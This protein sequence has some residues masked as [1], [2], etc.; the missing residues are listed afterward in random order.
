MGHSVS[1]LRGALNQPLFTDIRGPSFAARPHI[2]VCESGLY[3]TWA[4]DKKIAQRRT[5]DRTAV[6]H[7]QGGSPER[8]GA[9]GAY[10]LD[11]QDWAPYELRP[12][13]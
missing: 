5:D 8:K 11:P 1:L 6:G 2:F 10:A 3:G 7:E 12:K 9:G 4:L 13:L